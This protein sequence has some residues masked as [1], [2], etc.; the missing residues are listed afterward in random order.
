MANINNVDI[1]K[2]MEICPDWTGIVNQIRRVQ[3][4]VNSGA[5]RNI[6]KF[7]LDGRIN[8]F[9]NNFKPSAIGWSNPNN[10]ATFGPRRRCILDIALRSKSV[11]KAIVNN[12]E[13][14]TIKKFSKY[15]IVFERNN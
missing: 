7:A 13:I 10:P 3:K 6:N 4:K 2:L 5:A 11:K 12:A 14:I 8:S 1:E 9:S 15:V